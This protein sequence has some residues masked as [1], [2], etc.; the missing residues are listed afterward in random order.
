M[1]HCSRGDPQPFGA[2]VQRDGMNFALYAPKATQVI[3]SLFQPETLDLLQEIPL[4]PVG[5][6][7]G[8]IWHVLIHNLP[9]NLFYAYRVDGVSD[10]NNGR[11]YNKAE[12]LF[13]PYAKELSTTNEWRK[14]SHY[15]ADVTPPYRP[16]GALMTDHTFDWDDDKPLNH[17][18]QS[19]IL[20]EMHVR[21]FTEHESSGINNRGTYLGILEK[22]QYLKELGINAL[23]LM[24]VFEFNELD[25]AKTNPVTHDRLYNYWGYMTVNFF[26]PMNRFA[27]KE[28]I[29]TAINEFKTLVKGC[30]EQG[31]EVIL[32]V[33][34]NHTGE[35]NQQG[36]ILSYKGIANDIYYI[37]DKN[38][39]YANY[40][41]TGNTFNC[42]HPVVR[43]LIVDSLRYWVSEMHVDG[44]RFDLGS[45]FYR[46]RQGEPM[47]LPPIVEEIT[48]DP[49]LSKVKLISEPW[50]AGGL[51][52]VGGFFP[53]SD[54]WAEWNGRY[55]DCIRRFFNGSH[56][57]KGELAT[58]ISG[59]Q[60]LYGQ[61]RSPC[62]SINFVIS[63]DGFTLKDLVSYSRKHNEANGE[64]NQDGSNHND[65]WNCGA[66]GETIN[67]K[68]NA[69]RERQMRNFHLVLM[70]SQGVPMI[71][72]GDEY[73]HT[74]KGNNNTWCQDNTLNWFLWDQLHTHSSFFRF[75]KLMIHFRK[76]HP[77]LKRAT[78]LTEKDIIW[79]GIKPLN[80]LWEANDQFLA[81]QLVDSDTQQDLYVAFN[82]SKQKLNVELPHPPE[83][84][85][86]HWVAE[87][88][89]PPPFDF[90]EDPTTKPQDDHMI[91]M[92][93][94]SAVILKAL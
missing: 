58:R 89:A 78:F 38:K 31:I 21:G 46:D 5:N 17:P 60:D 39:G 8:D 79:H 43:Q 16:L 45:I 27:T 61:G 19:L 42:N 52:Q 53:S 32:D 70:V 50:D 36:P 80:P 84:K 7:T 40:S 59:S 51:Y 68:I 64:N 23:E 73:G 11:L 26:S 20:Y 62:N 18:I 49:I 24:P 72:M 22:L 67:D 85:R 48:D 15:P 91:K 29:G 63:H 37:L 65:S 82:A 76:N 12:Y 90:I 10:P 94:H 93:S 87:T 71:C 30:H 14:C 25:Y 3:L 2:T 47:G 77:L 4:D 34:F 6:K 74:K 56:A 44:F 86:W 81:F 66:E 57:S 28:K 88:C 69:L 55:R 41:G 13:D 92:I 75:Y 1:F 33:V 54:R 9:D 35:G 83:G